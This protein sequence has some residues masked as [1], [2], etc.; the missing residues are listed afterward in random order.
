MAVYKVKKVSESDHRFSPPIIDRIV[1]DNGW[2]YIT[3][4]EIKF[5]PSY[6]VK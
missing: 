2:P 1:N 4:V 3:N 6:K 5:D